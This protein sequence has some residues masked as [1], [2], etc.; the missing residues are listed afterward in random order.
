[1]Q[2]KLCVGVYCVCRITQC[3]DHSQR[4]HGLLG[5]VQGVDVV[6][7]GVVQ[8]GV[9]VG[10]HLDPAGVDANLAHRLR[11]QQSDHGRH[12]A[13]QHGCDVLQQRA[14]TGP[15]TVIM[16]VCFTSLLYSK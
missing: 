16:V 4:V 10:Q 3:S 6:G 14:G 11:H 8:H 2:L 5:A 12:A 1:M 15:H 7:A 13:L 9:P